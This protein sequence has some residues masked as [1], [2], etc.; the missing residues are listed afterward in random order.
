MTLHGA[1][2]D[3]TNTVLV[4][5]FRPTEDLH[6]YTTLLHQLGTLHGLPLALYGD[7][8]NVFV[9]NDRHW[10]VQ[11]ELQGALKSLPENGP[12]P[13]RMAAHPNPRRERPA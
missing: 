12:P 9:R 3:A 1:I 8:L 10:S 4:L 11:E 6:G 7:R 2:D 5:G 13:G